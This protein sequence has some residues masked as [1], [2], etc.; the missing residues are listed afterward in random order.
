MS[1]L[2]PLPLSPAVLSFW[3]SVLTAPV[4]AGLAYL[5]SHDKLGYEFFRIGFISL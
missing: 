2:V 4:F 5:A 1:Q 3:M